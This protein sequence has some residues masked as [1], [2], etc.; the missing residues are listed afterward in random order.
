MMSLEMLEEVLQKVPNL[1][2]SLRH[3]NSKPSN[4]PCLIQV[5]LAQ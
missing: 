3:R 1:V 2:K 4:V 5:P